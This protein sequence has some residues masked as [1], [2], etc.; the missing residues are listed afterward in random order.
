MNTEEFIRIMDSG[1]VME[2]R[3]AIAVPNTPGICQ[4]KAIRTN[5]M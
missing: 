4:L 5:P 3:L 1:P 2:P